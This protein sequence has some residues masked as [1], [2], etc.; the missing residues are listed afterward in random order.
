ML[1]INQ[2]Y[3][4]PPLVGFVIIKSQNLKILNSCLLKPLFEKKDE[5]NKYL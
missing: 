1:K 3:K 2:I 5:K 4:N